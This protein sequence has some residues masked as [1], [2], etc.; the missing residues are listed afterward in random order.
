MGTRVHCWWE[1]KFLQQL[2]KSVWRF[3]KNLIWN[4]SV[5]Q[6]FCFWGIYPKEKKKTPSWKDFCIPIYLTALFTIAKLWK[7][8]K[9]P[10]TDER[11]PKK[12]GRYAMEYY[13]A[14]K[15]KEIF[16]FTTSWMEHESIVLSK[17]PERKTNI[18]WAHLHVESKKSKFKGTENMSR[19]KQN[20]WRWSKVTKFQ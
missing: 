19:G 17:M 6:Q 5:I 10:W 15:K 14:I 8:S 2:W 11:I 13:S 4:Y 7:Q 9:C 12:W 18:V 1:C 16:Q 20:G 3:L